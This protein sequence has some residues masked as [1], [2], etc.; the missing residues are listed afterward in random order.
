VRVLALIMAGGQGKRARWSIGPI[1]KPLLLVRGIPLIER[2][3]KILLR[4]GMRDMVVSVSAS[5]PQ[6]KRFVLTHGRY[7]IESAGGT[8]EIIEEHSPRGNIGCAAELHGRAETVLV[9]FADNLTTLDLRLLVDTHRRNDASLTMATHLEAVQLPFG[10]IE[11]VHGRVIAYREKPSH[12]MLICSGIYALGERALAA[13]PAD[14]PMGVSGLAQ[15]LLA[16]GE[17]VTEYRHCA[18]W[19][20]VNNADALRR[21]E[22]LLTEHEQ[23]FELLGS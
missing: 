15:T 23:A 12:L 6:I 8:L 1:P 4:Q 20:D 14:E 13:I 9:V 21:A 3:I 2:N 16:R 7:L 19:V 18:P 5:I 22:D 17:I 10:E 11:A